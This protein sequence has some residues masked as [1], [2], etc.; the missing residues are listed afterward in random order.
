[1]I[2]KFV[3]GLGKLALIAFSF[4][5]LTAL[6]LL[7]FSSFCMT[8]PMMRRSPRDQKLQAMTQLVTSAL[9]AVSI[10]SNLKD[11]E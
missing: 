8:Y 7:L 10:F 3:G 9:S 2:V 11:S 6:S 5:F 1:M 4:A